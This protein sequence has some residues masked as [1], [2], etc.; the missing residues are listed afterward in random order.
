LSALLFAPIKRLKGALKPL[1][2]G[3]GGLAVAERE[4]V[5]A[6]SGRAQRLGVRVGAREQSCERLNLR[7]TLN[8]PLKGSLAW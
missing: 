2:Q 5:G 1:K 6:A 7:V 3:V 4:G 8:R